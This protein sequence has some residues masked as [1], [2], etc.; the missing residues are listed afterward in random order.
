MEKKKIH[1]KVI[2]LQSD[3]KI[4]LSR[5][6]K[7]NREEEINVSLTYLERLHEGHNDWLLE[8]ENVI[9]LD[10]NLA[11]NVLVDEI[12]KILKFDV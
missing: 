10:G 4:C 12:A 1:F 2:Y 7:R 9:I 11:T 6:K 5:I 3:P 8:S